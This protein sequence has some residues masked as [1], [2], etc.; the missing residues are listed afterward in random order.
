MEDRRVLDSQ[1][2]GRLTLST[3]GVERS[4]RSRRVR[5]RPG[6]GRLTNRERLNRLLMLIQLQENRIASVRR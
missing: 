1:D 4:C 3:G 6:G 2:G 5:S